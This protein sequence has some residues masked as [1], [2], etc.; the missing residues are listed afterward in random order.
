MA[1]Q[2]WDCK[3]EGQ[4]ML[5]ERLKLQGGWLHAHILKSAAQLRRRS[6]AGPSYHSVQAVKIGARQLILGTCC[7]FARHHASRWQAIQTAPHAQAGSA[8]PHSSRPQ[9][10]CLQAAAS[11]SLAG[12]VVGRQR[13]HGGVLQRGLLV[14]QQHQVGLGV[15]GLCTG[16]GRGGEVDVAL[17]L[18]QSCCWCQPH[19][20]NCVRP[21]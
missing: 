2:Q 6:V 8:H 10:P 16:A 13:L 15:G 1:T 11:A 9:G 7:L 21:E 3:P 4:C 5:R 14:G 12:S 19:L 20:P 17:T 18:V